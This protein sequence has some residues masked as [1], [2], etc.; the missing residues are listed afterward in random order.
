MRILLIAISSILF[1]PFA[2]S[3]HSNLAQ[4]IG[5][6]FDKPGKIKWLRHYKGRIDDLNDIAVSLAYDGKH[7]RGQMT[8]LRSKETFILK[9]NIDKNNMLR[10]REID[11]Q[12]E[13]SGYLFGEFSDQNILGEWQNYNNSI[14]GS[15]QLI[16]VSEAVAFPSYCGDNKWIHL[17]QGKIAAEPAEIVLQKG[18][19]NHLRGLV[20]IQSMQESFELIGEIDENQ[21]FELT[22]KDSR[23]QVK[24]KLR[25]HIQNNQS[26]EARFLP[27]DGVEGPADFRLTDAMTVGCIE[28]ADYISSYDITYPKTQNASFNRW[29]KR[30][31]EEWVGQCRDYTEEMKKVNQESVP[32][33]RATVRAFAWT[34]IDLFSQELISGIITFSNTWETEPKGDCFNFDLRNGKAIALDDLFVSDFDHQKFIRQHINER[35]GQHSLYRDYEYRKW[36]ANEGFN[37]FTI[38]KEGISF[39]TRFNAIYG[40]Q[41]ITIPYKILKPYLRQESPIAHLL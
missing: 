35:I 4:E 22:F 27:L 21:H 11:Q 39:S 23:S 15:L 29:I 20:Y 25:G 3:Q 5:E 24:G 2:N 36:L 26:I 9:G 7:C 6:L 13:T 14:G 40:Q 37:F 41:R 32:S 34:D 1:L 8:Y 38:R 33:L 28:Y 17:Y 19:D 12:G 18:S 31:T 16:G 10:L 30:Q